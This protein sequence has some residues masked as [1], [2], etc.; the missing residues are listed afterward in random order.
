MYGW[1]TA[2]CRTSRHKSEADD[3]HS[4]GGKHLACLTTQN[5]KSKR[6]Q[7]LYIELLPGGQQGNIRKTKDQSDNLSLSIILQVRPT[8]RESGNFRV[9]FK[10]GWNMAEW[11]GCCLLG[12]R[13]WGPMAYSIRASYYYFRAVIINL[14]SSPRPNPIGYLYLSTGQ[15]LCDTPGPRASVSEGSHLPIYQNCLQTSKSHKHAPILTLHNRN[16]KI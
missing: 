5:A 7:R 9:K 15:W 10:N 16:T 11:C 3:S 14:T 8:R 13:L 2:R 12:T 6:P 1:L 4:K